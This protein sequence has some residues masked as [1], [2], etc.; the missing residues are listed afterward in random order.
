[1]LGLKEH[2]ESDVSIEHFLCVSLYY[3]GK[4]PWSWLYA[5][6]DVI[7]KERMRVPIGLDCSIISQSINSQY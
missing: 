2:V 1:M 5:R 6:G 7:L 4:S 3:K